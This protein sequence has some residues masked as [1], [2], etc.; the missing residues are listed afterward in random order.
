VLEAHGVT[1]KPVRAPLA[2]KVMLLPTSEHDKKEHPLLGSCAAIVGSIMYI[3]NSTRPDLCYSAS[4]HV[5]ARFMANPC[6]AHLDQAIRLLRYLFG[7]K[8]YRLALGNVKLRITSSI[9]ENT[10]TFRALQQPF[11]RS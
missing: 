1:V 8:H 6:D 2:H 3:A 4:A 9:P 10:G 7:S 5:L 11:R